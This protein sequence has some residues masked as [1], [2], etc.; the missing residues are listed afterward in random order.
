M[1]IN[2]KK[3]STFLILVFVFLGQTVVAQNQIRIFK[4]AL[5]LP[6]NSKKSGISNVNVIS[7]DYYSG[8]KLA[9]KSLKKEG[10]NIQLYVFDSDKDSTGLDN[11]LN[12]VDMPKMDLIIGPFYDDPLSKVEQFATKYQIPVVSPLRFH[13][14]TEETPV[15]NFFAPDSILLLASVEKIHR[16]M[17]NHNLVFVGESTG[18]SKRMAKLAQKYADSLGYKK[19]RTVTYENSK[20]SPV[21]TP[22]DST[23]L[24]I[25]TSLDR[26]K[27]AYNNLV[28]DKK[29]SYV[30]GNPEWMEKAKT[31]AASETGLTKIIYPEVSIPL[32]DSAFSYFESKYKGNYFVKPT[33]YSYMGYDQT[34]W[35]CYGLMAFGPK[36]YQHLPEAEFRGLLMNIQMSIDENN[37]CTNHGVHFVTSWYSMK[38]FKP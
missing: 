7:H 12:H 26:N 21:F 11:V 9:L 8:V 23:I 10:L 25:C 38:E 22:G 33:P 14:P 28:K 4:V 15:I 13:A 1:G 29:S 3:I 36:F 6:F 37:M 30:L 18:K 24:I 16:M 27:T 34:L 19:T 35:L 2:M 5:L 31:A 20:F 32:K 17:P